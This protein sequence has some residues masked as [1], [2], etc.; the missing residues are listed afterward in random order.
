MLQGLGFILSFS[1][2]GLGLVQRHQYPFSVLI[3]VSHQDTNMDALPRRG[4]VL[5]DVA[6]AERFLNFAATMPFET[7]NPDPRATP[8]FQYPLY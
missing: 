3:T 6:R 2:Q 5:K 4:T 1:V 8:V 7:R